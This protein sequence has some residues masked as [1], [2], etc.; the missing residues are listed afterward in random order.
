M[1]KEGFHKSFDELF[2]LNSQR[3]Q[4]RLEA[5]PDSIIWEVRQCFSLLFLPDEGRVRV[6]SEHLKIFVHE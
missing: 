5:G 3:N 6:M 2:T 1:L 4:E